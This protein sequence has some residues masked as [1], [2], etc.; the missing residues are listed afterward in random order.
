MVRCCGQRGV[1]LALAGVCAGLGDAAHGFVAG[2][3][4][5][6]HA[7]EVRHC[8]GV[9]QALRPR[10]DAAPLDIDHDVLGTG[11]VQRQ[12]AERQAFGSSKH[13]RH[14]FHLRPPEAVRADT[15]SVF[16]QRILT[17]QY[18]N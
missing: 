2:H 4:G 11:G 5:V 6:A 1:L 17:V 16:R 18:V 12:A 9:E 15:A 8:P 7:G 10:A 3:Q 13:D 14:C